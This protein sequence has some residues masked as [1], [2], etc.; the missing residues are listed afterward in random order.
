VFRR[1]L[2]GGLFASHHPQR[3][4]TFDLDASVK[5]I[6]EPAEVDQAEVMGGNLARS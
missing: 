3:E 5:G 4:S 2:D 1:G 6:G